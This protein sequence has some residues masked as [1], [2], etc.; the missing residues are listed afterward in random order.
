MPPKQ[1]W[2]DTG[3][4]ESIAIIEWGYNGSKF[5]RRP[6][7]MDEDKVQLGMEVLDSSTLKLYNDAIKVVENKK[8]KASNKQ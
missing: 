6:I 5:I 4:G 3:L 2:V 7:L 1:I 8:K